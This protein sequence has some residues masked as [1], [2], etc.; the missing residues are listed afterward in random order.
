[1]VGRLLQH[2]PH[3][4]AAKIDNPGYSNNGLLP[5][6]LALGA[7][8]PYEIKASAEAIGMILAAHPQVRTAQPHRGPVDPLLQSHLG[9]RTKGGALP[10]WSSCRLFLGPGFRLGARWNRL[11]EAVKTHKT[12]EKTG[13]KWARYGLR[14]VNKEGTGGI[15]WKVHSTTPSP[16]LA[17]V[18]TES[19]AS[20]IA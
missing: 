19:W 3:A 5:L 20:T 12:R 17:K 6:H 13:K 10:S 9:C 4:A 16:K 18:E 1:M 11:G 8:Y 14:S 2:H 7:F 15:T